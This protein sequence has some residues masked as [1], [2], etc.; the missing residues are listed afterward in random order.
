MHQK[1]MNKAQSLWTKYF[2]HLEGPPPQCHHVIDTYIVVW[3][4]GHSS[5]STRTTALSLEMLS[6]L[7]VS[8]TFPPGLNSYMHDW[9]AVAHMQ[10]TATNA[11]QLTRY[12]ISFNVL[13]AGEN[14]QQV[15][16]VPRLYLRTI[17]TL[18]SNGK[19]STVRR[20]FVIR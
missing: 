6:Q 20:R 4:M 19:D 11:Q 7:A 1:G 16:L 15:K 8:S 14:R 18:S 12:V 10:L 13:Q 5:V 3:P 9:R 2:R 17:H